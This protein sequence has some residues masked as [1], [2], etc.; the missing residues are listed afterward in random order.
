VA[1]LAAV[2][3]RHRPDDLSAGPR[4][5][6]LAGLRVDEGQPDRPAVLGVRDLPVVRGRRGDG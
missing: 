3:A 2:A 1:E 6:D 5:R 4:L